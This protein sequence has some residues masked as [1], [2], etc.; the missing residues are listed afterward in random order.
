MSLRVQIDP[1][2]F[3]QT[4]SGHAVVEDHGIDTVEIDLLS[5]HEVV[6]EVR[7]G[8]NL[9]RRYLRPSRRVTIVSDRTGIPEV[10]FRFARV[11]VPQGS[12]RIYLGLD[13]GVGKV[14]SLRHGMLVSVCRK[15]RDL[16]LWFP[17]APM[18]ALFDQHGRVKRQ[19]GTA[20][21]EIS[22][23]SDVTRL[24]VNTICD[25]EQELCIPFVVVTGQR[26]AFEEELQDLSRMAHPPIIKSEWFVARS[27]IDLWKHLIDGE[28]FDPRPSR[29][30]GG[31]FVCQQCAY[32]W[33]SYLQ[34]LHRST[35]MGILRVLA[36]EIAWSVRVGLLKH[37][38]WSHGFWCEPP[39]THMRFV[40]D[41][42]QLLISEA[43]VLGEGEWI[44]D[45]AKAMGSVIRTRTDTLDGDELW[46]LHDSLEVD[47]SASAKGPSVLGSTRGN[48]LCLNTHVQALTI[49]QRLLSRPDELR[50]DFLEDAYRR[51]L[52]ALKRILMLRPAEPLYELIGNCVV[53]AVTSKLQSGFSSK[54][55]RF[56]F[57]RVLRR[58]YWRARRVYPRIVY[59]NGFIE[60][61]MTSAMLA[62]DYHVLNLKDLLALYEGDPQPWLEPVIQ[63][64]VGFLFRLDPKLA[65]KR[66]PLLIESV[67]VLRSYDRLFGGGDPQAIDEVERAIQ[68]QYSGHSLDACLAEALPP[69]E[70][71]VSEPNPDS[72]PKG[73]IQESAG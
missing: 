42:L 21:I 11:V 53:P 28:V 71:T 18:L 34:W 72:R 31:R 33:W 36:R 63:N 2:D 64:G 44:D 24:L 23:T 20:T 54:L 55:I 66:S 30:G 8:P 9:V 7:G 60:R 39:E 38:E 61:D 27:P 3:W 68:D 26:Q 69:R 52:D 58:L 35:G 65:L 46:F 13:P 25:S 17:C 47:R 19:S 16:T 5:D 29:Q 10:E 57:F 67:D 15:G 56:L 59:P 4:A 12:C 40:F 50:S 48:T 62:D 22:T 70:S 6:D 43:E 73:G 1:W 37:G 45:A 14:L 41:G 32:A 49:L 51:G